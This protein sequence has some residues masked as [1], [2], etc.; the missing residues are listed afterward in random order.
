MFLP[1]CSRTEYVEGG[2]YYTEGEAGTYAVLK[3][4]K[5]DDGGY[6]LR[7]YSNM[8]SEPPDHIDES[9]LYIVGADHKPNETLGM[10][11]V[12]ISKDSFTSWNAHFIQQSTVKVEELDGYKIWRD[13]SGNY[14]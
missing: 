3:I 7:L 2:L 6:H 5:I 1:S 9:T 14:F 12:P 8:Y 11:H 4:L 13:A 10:G